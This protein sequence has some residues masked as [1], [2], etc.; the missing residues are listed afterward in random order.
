VQQAERLLA[1]AEQGYE[2]GVKIRLEVEGA[3]LNLV[4]ARG[5]LAQARRDYRV[6]LVNLA[7]ATGMRGEGRE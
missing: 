4:Q 2:L 7:W 6:S 5:N 3:E 1:M